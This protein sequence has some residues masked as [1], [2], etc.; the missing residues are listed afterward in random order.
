MIHLL[1][2]TRPE[3]VLRTEIYMNKMT[4]ERNHCYNS[5]DFKLYCLPRQHCDLHSWDQ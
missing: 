2:K 3:S 1:N 5:G 4:Q